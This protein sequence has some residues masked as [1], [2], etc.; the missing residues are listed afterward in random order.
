M[1]PVAETDALALYYD[2]E[3]TAIAVLD[4]RSGKVWRSNPEDLDS[5]PIASPYEKEA[6]ASQVTVNYRDDIGT[7]GTFTSYAMSVA[8]GQFKTESIENGIR[9]TYSSATP[10]PAS[11]RCRRKSARPGSKRRS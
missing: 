5:D 10:K 1:K 11:M 8:N 6:L 3:T 4:K 7:L 2:E 9:I